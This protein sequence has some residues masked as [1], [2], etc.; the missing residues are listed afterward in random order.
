MAREF[1][2][3]LAYPLNVGGVESFVASTDFELDLLSFSERLEAVHCDRRE[4]HEDVFTAL[5]FNEAIALGIIEPL[6]FPFG[7]SSS[8]LRD[9]TDPARRCAGQGRR[10]LCGRLY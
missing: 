9:E 2:E 10:R 3:G 8:L 6:H 4:M 7:H 1:D 5:L